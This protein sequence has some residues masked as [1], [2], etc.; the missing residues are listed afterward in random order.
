MRS[1]AE[2]KPY[3]GWFPPEGLE[4]VRVDEAGTPT[5]RAEFLR[6]HGG[7]EVPDRTCF[8]RVGKELVD[9]CRACR[10]ITIDP[11]GRAPSHDA[12]T[13]ELLV[14]DRYVFPIT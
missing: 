6:V 11:D 8:E 13:L 4:D 9:Q 14:C 7:T 3:P 2:G 1:A 10:A 12:G 5:T